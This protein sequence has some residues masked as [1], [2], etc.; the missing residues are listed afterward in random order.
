MPCLHNKL[1]SPDRLRKPSTRATTEERQRRAEQIRAAMAEERLARLKQEQV[2][3]QQRRAAGKVRQ[4][5]FTV[6]C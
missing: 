1:S 6:A 5:W 4:L 3:K 2:A